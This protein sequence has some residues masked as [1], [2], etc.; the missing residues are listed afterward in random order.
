MSRHFF[1][2]NELS[3]GG[4]SARVNGVQYGEDLIRLKE[5]MNRLYA[6]EANPPKLMAP[7]GFF[8][9]KWFADMLQT[10]GPNVVD[11]VSHHIYNLGAGH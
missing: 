6:K 9:A 4:V 5:L 7:G 2:G 10:S 11:V 1:L 8:D 3:A